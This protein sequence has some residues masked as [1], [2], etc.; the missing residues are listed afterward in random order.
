V[1]VKLIASAV[2]KIHRDILAVLSGAGFRQ[3]EVDDR[4]YEMVGAGPEKFK[5]HIQR[6]SASRKFTP[7]SA[8]V[9][10]D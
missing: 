5:H 4:S 9:K 3:R 6:D 7:T 2:Q 10:L 8:K 1:P